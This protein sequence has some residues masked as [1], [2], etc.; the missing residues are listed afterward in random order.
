[1]LIRFK[2]LKSFDLRG[3][4]GTRH[5]VTDLFMRK[6]DFGLTHVV[7]RLG[8]WYERRECAV[9]IGAF[10]APDL[11]AGLWT[12]SV[13]EADVKAAGDGPVAALAGGEDEAVSAEALPARECEMS[14]AQEGGIARLSRLVDL[15]VEASDG[16][17]GTVMDAIVETAGWEVASLVVHAGPTGTEH[18]RVIPTGM[19]SALDLDAGAVRL[20]CGTAAVS[21]SP[22]LHE[23]GDRIEGHWWNRVLGYYGLG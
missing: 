4:D 16:R 3:E 13:A 1:M 10:D 18:Q 22:D 21:G 14:A 7:M 23:V 6:E 12:A 11:D 20:R 17:A 5:G 8:A 15:P 2:D 19:I 9:R